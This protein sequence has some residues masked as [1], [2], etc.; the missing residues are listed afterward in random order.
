[1][2]SI[3]E[4]EYARFNA[5]GVKPGVEGSFLTSIDLNAELSNNFAA[6]ISIGSQAN[7]SQRSGNATSFSNY[8]AG[9]KDRII[10]EK[11]LSTE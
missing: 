7:G 6:M 10:P 3:E 4:K 2:K 11:T 9:L 8:N 5:F 1:M